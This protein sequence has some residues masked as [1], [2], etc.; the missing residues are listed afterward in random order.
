MVKEWGVPTHPGDTFLTAVGIPALLAGMYNVNTD[1]Q[2]LFDKAKRVTELTDKLGVSEGIRITPAPVSRI[3]DARP[4]LTLADLRNVL[5]APVHAASAG[6]AE[7]QFSSRILEPKYWIVFERDADQQR[8][9]GK[10]DAL[11]P[12]LAARSP[13]RPEITIEVVALG[14][15]FL[16]VAAGGARV[17]SEAMMLAVDLK[18]EY[19]LPIGLQEVPRGLLR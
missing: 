5:V 9:N 12:R 6:P 16:V 1:A 4:G 3:E 2:Q 18:R 15:E 7:P 17:R 8:A 19:Q 13:N 14:R 11:R 10:A